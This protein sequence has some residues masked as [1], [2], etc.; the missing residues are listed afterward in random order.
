M[1]QLRR[2]EVLRNNPALADKD[3]N[4][5]SR[6]DEKGVEREVWKEQREK[7][8][9]DEEAMAADGTK[10]RND[11]YSEEKREAIKQSALGGLFNKDPRIRLS[12]I[13]FLRRIGPDESMMESV[14]SARS[15]ASNVDDVKSLPET[16]DYLNRFLD[17]NI[18]TRDKSKDAITYKW[19]RYEGILP[20]K[21]LEKEEPDQVENVLNPAYKPDFEYLFPFESAIEKRKIRYWGTYQIKSPGEELNK[22]YQFIQRRK[23]VRAIKRGDVAA[24]TKLSRADFGILSQPIDDEYMLRVPFASFHTTVDR[25]TTPSEARPSPWAVFKADDI[26]VIKRGIDSTNFLVQKGT[27]EY[28][29]K[30]YNFYKGFKRDD[31]VKKEIRDAV[32]GE[33]EKLPDE[34]KGILGIITSRAVT[35]G[36]SL[37]YDR[38]V[39]KGG[40][41]EKE[42]TETIRDKT[43]TPTGDTNPVPSTSTKPTDPAAGGTGTGGTGTGGTGTGDTGTGGTGTGTGGTG[44]GGTTTPPGAGK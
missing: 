40:T 11:S 22:L 44:T 12:S 16:D 30:F 24:I 39:P 31:S 34:L 41:M 1:D 13:H 32:L 38:K 28:L 6:K 23:L 18:Y 42:S 25:K 37:T 19:H 29:V 9:V 27:C 10:Y 36:S 8:F 14:I 3:G 26:R 2:Q 21:D 7:V 4:L 43:P 17:T 33:I 20:D 15:I 35:A 5:L